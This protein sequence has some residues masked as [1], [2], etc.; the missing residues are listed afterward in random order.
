MAVGFVLIWFL[1]EAPL[2][3]QSGMQRRASVS[4]DDEQRV[5]AAVT[6]E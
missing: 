1:K 6:G 4:V 3:L 2:S 5:P